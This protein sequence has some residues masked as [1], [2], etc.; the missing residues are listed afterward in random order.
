MHQ[1]DV[2]SIQFFF[3]RML[4]GIYDKMTKKENGSDTQ[5][6]GCHGTDQRG[7][8][9]V[10]LLRITYEWAKDRFSTYR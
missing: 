4:R 6:D 9:L 2:N 3:A 5:Q 8:T 10:T 1:N 7:C